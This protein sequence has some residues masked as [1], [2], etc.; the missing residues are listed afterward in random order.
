A[1]M[2]NSAGNFMVNQEQARIM[3]QQAKQAELDT[4]KK[5][6][7]Q[8]QWE[9]ANTPTFTEEQVPISNRIVFRMVTNPQEWEIVAG[10]TL[11]RLVPFVNTLAAKGIMGPTVPL[12]PTQVNQLN[13]TVGGQGPK[14]GLF[15]SGEDLEWPLNL[16]G[17]EQEKLDGMIKKA[18]AE[19][20]KG[21]L[22]P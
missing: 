5:A 9:K 12:D 2:L 16:Q 19:T 21:K 1:D 11:N 18:V 10:V 13:V 8:M 17:P 3:N 15:R 20:M 4:K 7:E 22:T 6:F 14:V